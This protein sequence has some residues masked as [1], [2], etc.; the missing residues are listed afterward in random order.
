VASKKKKKS[1][2]KFKIPISPHNVFIFNKRPQ[3]WLQNAKKKE[4]VHE[5]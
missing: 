3:K 4:K 1:Q 5:V 2:E